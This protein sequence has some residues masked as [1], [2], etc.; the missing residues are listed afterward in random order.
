DL[1]KVYR[2]WSW[3]RRREVHALRGVSLQ[4][5]AGEVFGLLGPNGA[6]KTT[7][8]KTLL[9][10]VR[11]SGGGASLFG[12]PAGSTQA[13]Q[14]VGYLPESL[15]VDRHHTARSALR[16]YGRM[17]RMGP[18]EINRRSDELLELV[19]LRGRDKESV[20]RFSKGMYQ[21]LGLAQAL[22]H[23]PSLLVLDEPTDGLDPVGRN[24]VRNVIQR[25]SDS[26]KTIF[27][28]SHILQE[29]ELV[30]T[31][32]AIMALGEIKAIGPIAEL[33]KSGQAS[34]VFL[35]IAHS[36]TQS[37]ESVRSV[38]AN[39][40][41]V[42]PAT[43]DPADESV[44][45]VSVDQRP[46]ANEWTMNVGLSDQAATDR[47]VDRLRAANFSILHLET[48]QASLEETFMRLV[49]QPSAVE[50]EPIA[51]SSG[52]ATDSQVTDEI[53]A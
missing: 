19:G 29:V 4:A 34:P 53:S 51:T 20:R 1:R 31:R 14:K 23:D 52:H 9:G 30:C 3:G 22:M 42:D 21:R 18:S 2:S 15:R 48:K 44:E 7:L 6:G 49:N 12:L 35:R 10:V 39:D 32:V 5:H 46:S 26:G 13:R 24:E 27:L 47:L 38:V 33:A 40:P 17:S 43:S 37:I 16:Y 50:A 25:L 28:N 8:I 11:P 45:L 36:E 41:V